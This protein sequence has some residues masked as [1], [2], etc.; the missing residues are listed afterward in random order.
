M[1]ALACPQQGGYR[2]APPA[3]VSNEVAL[4]C[5]HQGGYR[6]APPARVSTL[7]L[8]WLAPNKGVIGKRLRCGLATK[9]RWL[10]PI[11]GV[12]GKRL[13]RGLAHYVCVGLPP[14]RGL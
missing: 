2:Q 6:Q 9:L 3:Q 13:R 7:C 5:P 11:K 4:A 1:F 8:R 10:A 14:T 12:I